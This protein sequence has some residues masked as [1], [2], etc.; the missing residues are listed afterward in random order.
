[1]N[2]T[3]SSLTFDSFVLMLF[4]LVYCNVYCEKYYKLFKNGMVIIHFLFDF[5]KMLF[6]FCAI[7]QEIITEFNSGGTTL[8]NCIVMA[9]FFIGGITGF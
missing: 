4:K 2:I 5:F 8:L 1:M 3:L 7:D 6:L 9:N